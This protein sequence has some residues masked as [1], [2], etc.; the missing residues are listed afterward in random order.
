MIGHNRPSLFFLSAAIVVGVLLYAGLV[1]ATGL[2]TMS[3][4]K[5]LLAR[6]R[7]LQ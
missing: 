2:V 4:L 7:E 5:S 3:D 1:V 6:G